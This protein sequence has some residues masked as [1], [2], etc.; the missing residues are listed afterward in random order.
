MKVFKAAKILQPA[1]RAT[2]K[3]KRFAVK[4]SNWILALIALG[5][6][7]GAVEEFTRAT[8]KAVKLCEEKDVKGTKDVIKTVWKLYLPGVGFILVTTIATCSNAHLNAKRLATVTG[9]WAASQADLEAFK[10]KAREMLGDTKAKKLEESTASEKI[11]NNPPNEAAIFDTGHGNMLFMMELTG[12]YFRANPDYIE[13]QIAGFN[14]DM[15]KTVDGVMDVNDLTERFNLPKC[16]LGKSFWD[17][18]EMVDHGYNEIKVRLQPGEWVEINGRREMA[19]IVM[20]EPDPTL[21]F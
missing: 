13:A 3:L 19:S 8:I 12:Q 16:K 14:L 10:T 17:H 21:P 1:L 4:N 15:S 6:T 5:G 20:C 18:Y 2:S 9:L 11:K 7:I